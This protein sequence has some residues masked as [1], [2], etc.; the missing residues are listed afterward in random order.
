VH[1]L[2]YGAGNV[3]SVRNAVVAC[4]FDVVDIVSPADILSADKLIFPGVGSFGFCME[5]LREGGFVEPLKK[6]IAQ[7]RPLLGVCLGMQLFFEASEE[8]PGVAGLGIIPGTV[9][10]FDESCVGA[11]PHMGW[12]GT[13]AVAGRED[14]TLLTGI[15]GTDKM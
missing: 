14:S 1:L 8:S 3:R 4:G 15:A 10:R 12:N 2:D 11:V 7:D 13:R 6:Y 9:A 5:R